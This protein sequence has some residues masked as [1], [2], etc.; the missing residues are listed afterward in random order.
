MNFSPGIRELDLAADLAS[1]MMRYKIEPVVVLVAGDSR[2]Q[3]RRH[4]LPTENRIHEY[5]LAA[6]CGRRQGLIA[7]VTRSVSLRPLSSSLADR[8]DAAAFVDAIAI[9]SSRSGISLEE[10]LNRIKQAYADRGFANEWQMHHQGGITGYYTRAALAKPGAHQVLKPGMVVAW[11]PSVQ[12]T[13]TEDT[14]LVSTDHP[15]IMTLSASRWPIR[16]YW[17]PPFVIKRPEILVRA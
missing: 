6:V 5:A 13:K 4:P 11:N 10:I 3:L 2:T 12:G 15:E 14:C 1:A 7:S 8:H 17:M 9:S 16:E